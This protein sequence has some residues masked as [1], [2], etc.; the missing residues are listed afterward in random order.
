MGFDQA[1]GFYHET[2][3]KQEVVA[4]FKIVGSGSYRFSD[5]YLHYFLIMKGIYAP[6]K[7]VGIFWLVMGLVILLASIFPPNRIGKIV[8]L[9]AG[10]LLVAMGS[11]FIFLN[12]KFGP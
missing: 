3:P 12:R 2:S 5:F 11:F 6:L 8:D 4:R 7:I 10:G 9:L 1:Q